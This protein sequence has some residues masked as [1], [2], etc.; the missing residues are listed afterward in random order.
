MIGDLHDWGN[1]HTIYK[2][3]SVWVVE[4][5]G[6]QG[7]ASS[8]HIHRKMAN[9]F[10]CLSGTIDIHVGHVLAKRLDPGDSYYVPAGLPHKIVFKTK[11]E[12]IETYYA[13]PG[14]WIDEND[15]VRFTKAKAA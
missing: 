14:E 5:C 10:Y 1:S 11:A 4:L 3:A 15:I 2:D 8:L 12:A 7:G 13:A 9:H 6:R